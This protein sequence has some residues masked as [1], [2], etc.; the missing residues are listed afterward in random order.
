M[1]KKPLI[2]C[3]LT[4]AVHTS[5][6]TQFPFARPELKCK[7]WLANKKLKIVKSS[8]S[9]IVRHAIL[10][11]DDPYAR[12][13]SSWDLESITR[14]GRKQS[15]ERAISSLHRRNWRCCL[16]CKGIESPQW[17]EVRR[18]EPYRYS[19]GERFCPGAVRDPVLHNLLQEGGKC[20]KMLY[21][22]VET[23]QFPEFIGLILLKWVLTLDTT[24]NLRIAVSVRA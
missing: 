7:W 11:R 5:S 13:V 22:G 24:T 14:V 9:F 15:H 12:V 19:T 16:I 4:L 17:H 23:R 21:Q 6:K 3:V 18:R 20:R 2:V 10:P 8:R 1:R